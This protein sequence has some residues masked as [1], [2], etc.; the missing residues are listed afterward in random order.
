MLHE[1]EVALWYGL[2][3]PK[4]VA[5]IPI[6]EVGVGAWHP[7]F[8]A[9]FWQAALD[10]EELEPTDVRAGRWRRVPRYGGPDE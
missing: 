4:R 8:A 6:M 5:R 10:L 3:F 2:R 9:R 1:T 7:V